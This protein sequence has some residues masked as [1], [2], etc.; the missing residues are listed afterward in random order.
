MFAKVLAAV[1]VVPGS[2]GVPL[3]EECRGAA[4]DDLGAVFLVDPDVAVDTGAGA[5]AD[6]LRRRQS[7]WRWRLPKRF[8][9]YHSPRNS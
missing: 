5:L 3:R 1:V 6:L 2:P 4:E 7:C 9:R 8:S